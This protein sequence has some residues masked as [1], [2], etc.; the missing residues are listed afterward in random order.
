VASL[1]ASGLSIPL[2]DEIAG[3]GAAIVGVSCNED[4]AEAKTACSGRLT[5][6]G[7]LNGIEMRRWTAD[8]AEAAVKDAIK[9]A[10]PGGGYILSDSHGE[11]PHQVPAEVLLA[12]SEAVREWGRYPLTW[13]DNG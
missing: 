9:R 12:I 8:Q 6:L 13:L 10:A 5:I 7:N 11:I 1:F 4:L 3:T 2:L